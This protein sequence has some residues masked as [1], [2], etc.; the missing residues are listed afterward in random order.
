MEKQIT[1]ADCF[2]LGRA[3]YCMQCIRM[4]KGYKDMFILNESEPDTTNTNT[5]ACYCKQ[6][7]ENS[8]QSVKR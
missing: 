1:C 6:K 4:G 8:E 7:Q 5:A 2:H 3:V